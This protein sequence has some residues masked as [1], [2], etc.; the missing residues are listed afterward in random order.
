MTQALARFIYRWRYPLSAVAIAG[1][2]AL[3]PRANF[4]NIDNDITAWFSRDDPVFQDYERFR[5]EFGGTRAL[6]VAVESDRLFT[7]EGLQFLKDATA[8]IERVETVEYV[9]SLATTNVVQTGADGLEVRAL[10][11]R[12]GEIPPAEIRDRA[13]GDAL[14]R[15]DLVSE[16]GRVAAFVI[17]F[18]EDRIDAVRA[19]VIA[20]VKEIVESRAPPG[21]AAYYNGS[22]EISETYNRITLANQQTFIPPILLVTLTVLYVMFRSIRKT[23]LT[24]FGIALSVFWTLGIYSLLG[25]TY[26]ILTSMIVPLVVVLAIADD[27]HMMQHYAHERRTSTSEQ[28]FIRT[29]THM[30]PPLF[31]ASGTTALGMLSLATS[32]IVAVQSFGV[33]SAVGVMVDFAISIV[34]IPTALTLVRFEPE[35]APQERYLAGPLDRVARFAT[36]RPGLVIAVAAVVGIAA[37][38]GMTRLRVDTN[39][40]NFFSA[41]HPLAQ[42]ARIIDTNLAGVY[43]FD[44]LFEGPPGSLQTPDALARLDRLAAELLHLP[45][46]RKVTSVADYVKRIN[47]ELHDGDPRAARIPSDPE[48]IAQELF[49]FGLSDAGRR[50]LERMLSSDHSRARMTVKFASMSSDIVFEQIRHADRLAKAAFAGSTIQATATGSGRLWSQLDHYLVVSQLSSFA[51]AFVTVFGVIFIVFRSARFGMLAIVPNVFPVLAVLGVMGWLGISL[52]VA[53][54]MLASVALGVVDDDT[55]HFINRYRRECW[56]GATTNDAIFIATG[57]EGRASLTTAL[58]NS[59]GYGVLMLSEYK[60]TAWFGGLLALTMGVALLAEI[61]MLP[62]A[63]TLLPR[64]F[65]SDVV[66]RVHMRKKK[67]ACAAV[68]ALVALPA[69]AQAQV[70]GH[71]SVLIDTLPNADATELRA[72]IFAERKLTPS[73]ALTINLGGFVEGLLADRDDR[74]RRDA[75]ARPLDLFVEYAGARADVRAGVGRLVWGRLDEV[76]PSDVI[77]PIDVARFF[78]D[79]RSEARLPVAFGRARLFLPRDTTL[80]AVVVP[81]FRR[82]RFDE[83]DERTSPFTLEPRQLTIARRAPPVT[84]RNVQGGARLSSTTARVDWAIAAFRG[85]RAFPLYEAAVPDVVESLERRAPL[86]REQFPRFTM[87]AAD[88]ETTRGAWGLRGEAAAFLDDGLQSGALR[89][90]PGRSVDGGLGFDR[91]AGDY[92]VMGTLLVRRQQSDDDTVDATNVSIVGGATRMFARET[93]SVRLFGVYDASDRTGFIRAIAALSVRDS[94]ALEGS[95]GWFAGGSGAVPVLTTAS[96]ISRFADRDF[97]YVRVK[98]YF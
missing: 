95:I 63:I 6:I 68:L 43:S 98:A 12:L 83:L 96:L 84:G 29:V 58:I 87:I 7:R 59:A 70:H 1:A 60:P 3:A 62:A 20:R 4:T 81:W 88:F 75:I 90:L 26:N 2:L 67:A 15:G 40:I 42:S 50:D 10:L 44:F 85:I 31:G 47:R 18:D 37:L 91:K 36:S 24:L 55:I 82:G 27:V 52:N 93:R 54:I 5:K 17:T 92:T 8:D 39:H 57:H 21:L 23:L 45:Y 34:V 69:G 30:L 14:I 89:A 35:Q 71:A 41:R 97:L 19:R 16:D 66:R 9:H 94:L 72:R 77:N 78:F 38:A 64:F 13:L 53:T 86:L 28:A 79:G 65:A 73:P 76:Q 51:T 22:L 25:F 61:F 48:A 74:I 56:R 32:D 11:A 33:G 80:E 46:V 49:L